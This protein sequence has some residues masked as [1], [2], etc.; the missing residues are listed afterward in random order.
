MQLAIYGVQAATNIK[1]NFCTGV[2]KRTAIALLTCALVQSTW[3]KE[4]LP[5]WEL[6]LGAMTLT[7]PDY[8]GSDE[9][10]SLSFPLPIV[11]YR[12][13]ILRSDREGLEGV[14][15]ESDE[16]EF[17]V[18]FG[19][20]LPTDSTNK[21][22]EGMPNL[23]PLTEIGPELI[24]TYW[25]SDP[26]SA[27]IEL[28]LRLVTVLG[29]SPFIEYQGMVFNPKTGFAVKTRTNSNTELRWG[30]KAGVLFGF[31]QVNRYFY[32]VDEQFATPE[33]PAYQAKEGYMGMEIVS[34]MSAKFHKNW[35]VFAGVSAS[36]LEGAANQESPLFKKSHYTTFGI[37]IATTLYK[38]DALAPAR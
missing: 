14:L 19:G 12:G 23:K 34:T 10:K 4:R 26:Y 20:N 13:E 35:L 3:A 6:G 1:Y 36:N 22:R 31:D 24:Y 25:R 17:N 28:P 16:L 5:L 21:A 30:I 8:P 38:S 18:S 15:F 29:G 2:V 27:S 37:G 11:R 7:V 9:M 32:Q 33:R